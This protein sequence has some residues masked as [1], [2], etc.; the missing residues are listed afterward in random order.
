M[1]KLT[2]YAA[3]F[4]LIL[5][6]ASC[7]SASSDSGGSGPADVKSQVTVVTVE[8]RP[9]NDYVWIYA[10]STFQMKNMIRA[11]TTGYLTEVLIQPGQLVNKGQTLFQIETKEARALGKVLV[12]SLHYKGILTITSP[13]KG[14][15]VSVDHQTGDYVQVG[16]PLCTMADL[17]SF[18]FQMD[19]PFELTPYVHMG[20]PCEVALSD[21]QKL[22]GIVSSEVPSVDPSTQTQRFL[23]RL[24]TSQLLPENLVA[25]VRILKHQIASAQVLPKSAVLS[26]EAESSFWIMKLINDSTAIQ[27]P[28]T[29]GLETQ[30]SVQILSP[31]FTDSTR[32]LTSGNYGLSDTARVTIVPAS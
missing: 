29:K 25:R 27:V 16:D 1:R 14:F 17:S 28:I 6:W 13:E 11:N 32:V 15:V 19:V 3:G 22:E 12:D 21:G 31:V 10:T 20:M 5:L 7:S 4:G 18:V 2:F 24:N 26:N 9:M 30:D 23:I 8:H